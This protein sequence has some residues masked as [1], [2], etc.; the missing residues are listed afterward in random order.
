MKRNWLVPS[1]RMSDSPSVVSPQPV[2][3]ELARLLEGLGVVDEASAVLPGELVQLAAEQRHPF[4][5]ILRR[6]V[7][8]FQHPAGLKLDPPER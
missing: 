2:V 3:A 5:E 4:G 1:L 7:N 6:H 8:F